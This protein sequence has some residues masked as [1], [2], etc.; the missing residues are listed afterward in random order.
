VFTE[1]YN[2][3]GPLAVIRVRQILATSAPSLAD[4]ARH[5]TTAEVLSA[6]APAGR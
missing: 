5:L 4:Q 1:V 3:L 2:G 6:V